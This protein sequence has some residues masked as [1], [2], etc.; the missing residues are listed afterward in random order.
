MTSSPEPEQHHLFSG[1]QRRIVA[2]A[3]TGAAFFLIIALIV[4]VLAVA[5]DLLDMFS[6]VIWPL[7]T[8]AILATLL[9]PVVASLE[10]HL[11]LSRVMATVTLYGLFIITL[12]AIVVL[13]VIPLIG[14]F[15]QLLDFLSN[16]PTFLRDKYP[17]LLQQI[18]QRVGIADLK[19]WMEQAVS[20]VQDY[21]LPVLRRVAANLFSI[22][23]IVAG[24]GII[25]I[26]LFYLLLSDRNLVK[27]FETQLTFIKPGLRSD[28]IFLI[29]EFTAILTAFFRGQILIGLIMGVLLTIGFFSIG[30]EFALLLGLTIGILNIIPYLGTILGLASVLPIAWFQTDGGPLLAALALGVFIVVQLIESYILTPRIMGQRTGLHPMVIIISVFFW[31]AALGGIL[32]MILAIPLT[33]FFIIA[34]RLAKRKYLPSEQTTAAGDQTEQSGPSMA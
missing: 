21:A 13:I 29:S 24:L 12:G 10:K 14:Q 19:A 3:L 26:Y 23:G 32:G 2:G 34:W 22:F 5:R 20:Q 25:P 27:D 8:A 11:S 30:V 31:G 1:I 33:A 28:I 15:Y 7:A 16:L 18:Q 17:D 4:L 9:R 6:Q